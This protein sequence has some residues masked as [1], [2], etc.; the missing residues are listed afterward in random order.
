[1]CQEKMGQSTDCI[2]QSPR[3]ILGIVVGVEFGCGSHASTLNAYKK[4]TESLSSMPLA[5]L[6]FCWRG[7]KTRLQ[8]LISFYRSLSDLDLVTM[9][10]Q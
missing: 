6:L 7:P 5:P 3:F 1:M 9:N 4:A 8:A 10:V 2:M